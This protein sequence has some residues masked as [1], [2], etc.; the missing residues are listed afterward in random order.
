M[1]SY[2]FECK[3]SEYNNHFVLSFILRNEDDFKP[4][5]HPLNNEFSKRFHFIKT[6]DH[7]LSVIIDIGKYQQN[8]S[9]RLRALQN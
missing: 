1:F 7:N 6:K 2:V 4:A 9:I 3:E 5:P 8:L